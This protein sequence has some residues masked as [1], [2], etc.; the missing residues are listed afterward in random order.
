[1]KPEELFRARK[2]FNLDLSSPDEAVIA[3]AGNPN[4]GKSTIFN[5][6]TGMKQHTGNWPGKT[7]LRAQGE[8][9][10]EGRTYKLIDLP[11]TYSLFANS[12]DELVAR[13]FICFACPD[14]TVVVTDATSLERNLNLVLQIFEITDKVI[15]CV[16]LI[17]EAQRKAIYVDTN[18]LAEELGVPVIAAAGRR[19]IG[20]IELKFLIR[21]M[22]EGKIKT[23]PRIVK[24]DDEMEFLIARIQEKIAFLPVSR[25]IN[26][27]WIALRIL[28][29]DK[30]IWDGMIKY[31][32][33]ESGVRRA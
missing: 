1:M 17:D 2:R 11:G 16:N 6:L 12:S 9:S 33:E 21:D 8:Y 18:L 10:F 3:L 28:D 5:S 27:R 22:V 30:S 15:V 32:P 7:V 31:W 23:S 20:L 4:T 14:A 24:Y 25:F 26:P 19:G 13:D 29:G